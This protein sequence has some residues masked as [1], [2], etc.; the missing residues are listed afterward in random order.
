MGDQ[1]GAI[2]PYV[3]TGD[4]DGVQLVPFEGGG[5]DEEEAEE[6]EYDATGSGH[7]VMCLYLIGLRLLWAMAGLRSNRCQ[8]IRY[9]QF[10]GSEASGKD[11]GVASRKIKTYER[12]W[13][14]KIRTA[15]RPFSSSAKVPHELAFCFL[16]S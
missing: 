15:M 12:L 6:F 14:T 10:G 11:E 9:R 3:G 1:E 2:G 16:A 5:D 7:V 4:G 13:R 8:C